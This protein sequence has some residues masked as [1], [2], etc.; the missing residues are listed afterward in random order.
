MVRLS[1]LIESIKK[2]EVTLRRKEQLQLS[3]SITRTKRKYCQSTGLA[4]FG[5][6]GYV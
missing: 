2:K 1:E 6:K 4:K 3:F 5:S